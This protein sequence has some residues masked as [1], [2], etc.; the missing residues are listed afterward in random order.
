MST[1]VSAVAAAGPL[2]AGWSAHSWR[3]RRRIE[4]ARRDPLTNLS[5]RAG[6]ERDAARLLARASAVVVVV[7]DL[8]GFKQVND[9]YGHEVG[10]QVIRGAGGGLAEWNQDCGDG[11]VARLGGDEFVACFPADDLDRAHLALSG[12]HDMLT[13]PLWC[14]EQAVSVGA[15]VGGCW[16]PEP[17]AYD[18][19]AMLRRADEAMYT[20]KRNGGGVFVTDQPAPMQP[21]VN[22]RRAGRRG[23]TKGGR[24]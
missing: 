24:S 11:L 8:D 3:L 5:T 20:A 13:A 9:T 15:S 23:T 18:L 4:A 14:C 2:A 22:G 17:S 19:P 12:L 1:L 21:T 16:S 6:F 10:D 7:V